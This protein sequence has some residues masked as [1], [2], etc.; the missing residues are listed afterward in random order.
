MEEDLGGREPPLERR[1]SLPPNLPLSPR[2][3][4][5]STRFCMAKNFFRFAWR[6]CSWGKFFVRSGGADRLQSAAVALFL[7]VR[8]AG[9]AQAIRKRRFIPPH[10]SLTRQLPPKGKPSL[11]CANIANKISGSNKISNRTTEINRFPNSCIFSCC[12]K[13]KGI[14]KRLPLGGKLSRK[15]LMRGDKLH[16]RKAYT[17]PMRPP[18]NRVRS[19]T[20]QSKPPPVRNKN[21]PQEHPP[22][23]KRKKFSP[24]KGGCSWGKFGE[25]EGGLGGEGT[26]SERGTLL[27]PW[28]SPYL[29]SSAFPLRRLT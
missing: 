19:R 6:G 13:P 22:K 14:L 20:F 15:R 7:W 3:S 21:F 12:V 9:R 11:R 25:D 17:S 5:K 1:G 26:P 24:C 29:Q 27:L 10:Q 8:C 2:T 23:A 4:P 16:L 18:T 28:S